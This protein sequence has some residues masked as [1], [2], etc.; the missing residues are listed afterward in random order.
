MGLACTVTVVALESRSVPLED[1][2]L[3]KSSDTS[4]QGI[5]VSVSSS[6]ELSA[7]FLAM[8]FCVYCGNGVHER[9]GGCR[10]IITPRACAARGKALSVC[11]CC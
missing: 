4:G 3:E 6:F 5:P 8:P 10:A 11:R 1:K 7:F 9:R 2:G